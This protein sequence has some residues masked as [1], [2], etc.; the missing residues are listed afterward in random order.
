MITTGSRY[1][2]NGL[3]VLITQADGEKRLAVYVQRYAR[4]RAVNYRYRTAVSGDRFDSLAF[5]Y[6]GDPTFWWVLASANPE[7]F[8]PDEIAGGTVLRIPDADILR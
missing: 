5:E 7:V 8:Y 6:Y 1:R 2:K 4:P 3:A